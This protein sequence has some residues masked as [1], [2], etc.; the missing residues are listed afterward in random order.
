MIIKLESAFKKIER[1][2]KRLIEELN[3]YNKSQLDFHPKA[4]SW[5]MKQVC[6]HLIVAEENSLAY[7]RKKINAL[8]ELDN[9]GL[10]SKLR[11]AFLN[12]V[13]ST[14]IKFKAPKIVQ[15]KE[16][17]ADNL[18][19]EQL[20]DRWDKVRRELYNFADKLDHKA[21]EKL[22]FKHPFAGRFNIYQLFS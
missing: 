15:L 2:R 11:L 18:D 3:Q 14:K 19:Y 16:G 8:E 6:L 9:A 13:V 1:Q 22:L 7:M 10:W 5:N 12:S 4:G 20:I 17:D 21:S